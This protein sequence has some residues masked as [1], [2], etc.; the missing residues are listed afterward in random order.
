[1]RKILSYKEALKLV[2]K[3]NNFNFFKSEYKL[4]GYKVVTFSYFL[5]DFKH[6]DCPVEEDTSLHGYD[7]RGMTFVFNKDGSLYKR[8]LML[9][10]FFNLNQTE[11]TQYDKVKDKKIVSVT[12]KEDGSLIG[13]MQLPNKNL[14]AKT[15]GSFDNE[16]TRAA[17]KILKENKKL[18][19]FCE[20]TL[21]AGY[22]PIFEYVSWDNRIVLKYSKPELR[23]IGVRDNKDGTYIPGHKFPNMINTKIVKNVPDVTLDDLIKLTKEEENKEGWVVEFEDGQMIK[24]KTDWYFRIHGLRTMNVFREDFVI[25]AYL[26]EELDDLVSQL[27][28]KEDADAFKFIDRC[29]NAVDNYIKII[30]SKVEKL[31]K[32]YED[33]FESDWNYFAKHNNKEPFFGLAAIEIKQPN[34]YNKRK[35]DFIINKTKHL[36]DARSF[37]EKWSTMKDDAKSPWRK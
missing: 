6:F 8:F 5:C 35:I 2:D 19:D 12:V 24:L 25:K 3:Y 23:F 26:E 36:N 17:M 27:D 20:G 31:K 7:M 9:P 16:Q 32:L 15:I 18:Y 30:D 33:E 37:V 13:V 34:N 28:K 4:E 1:M 21:D 11:N 22:T 14:F 10:K 29:I